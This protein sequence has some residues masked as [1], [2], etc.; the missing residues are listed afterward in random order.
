[1]RRWLCRPAPFIC[2]NLSSPSE[3]PRPATTRRHFCEALPWRT[4][5]STTQLSTGRSPPLL[6]QRRR[7]PRPSSLHRAR[8]MSHAQQLAGSTGTRARGRGSHAD[9]VLGRVGKYEVGRRPSPHISLPAHHDLSELCFGGCCHLRC[10]AR[11]RAVHRCRPACEIG[12]RRRA[13]PQ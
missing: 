10:C 9:G 12:R 11:E 13:D 5:P 7:A 2:A 8:E 6:S 4:C 3:Q 1:M